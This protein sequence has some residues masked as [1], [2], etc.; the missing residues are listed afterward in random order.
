MQMQRLYS[1]Q[2][3]GQSKEALE[4][5]D[6]EPV[7]IILTDLFMPE[8]D[9]VELIRRLTSQTD[10]PFPPIVAV[11]GATHI[12]AESVGAAAAL[13]G[14]SAVLMKPFSKEQLAGAISFAF[15]QAKRSMRSAS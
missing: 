13:L 7:A 8:M 15:S 5:L 2:G 11:T 12:A 4:Q 1:L 3:M 10:K 9:G 6:D 14:A